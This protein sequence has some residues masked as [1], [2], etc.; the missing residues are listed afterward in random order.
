MSM[1]FMGSYNQC[2]SC[3]HI[4]DYED[5]CPQCGSDEINELNEREV[6]IYSRDRLIKEQFRLMKKV[7]KYTD[8]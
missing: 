2:Q 8:I 5:L 1:E 3:N 6:K 4:Y 7:N